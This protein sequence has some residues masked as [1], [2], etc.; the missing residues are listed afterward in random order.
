M[1]IPTVSRS[2][3]AVNDARVARQS[4]EQI[5]HQRRPWFAHDILL[6]PL[7]SDFVLHTVALQGEWFHCSSSVASHVR[8]G[9]TTAEYTAEAFF[10]PSSALPCFAWTCPFCVLQQNCTST[11]DWHCMRARTP[12]LPSGSAAHLAQRLNDGT[13]QCHPPRVLC[14][15][16]PLPE[17]RGRCG[18]TTGRRLQDVMSSC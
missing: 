16:K 2:T 4:K 8:L 13:L 17:N 18:W 10:S 7:R 9:V 14:F 15:S 1:S 3:V 11:P 12:A 5:F 6:C